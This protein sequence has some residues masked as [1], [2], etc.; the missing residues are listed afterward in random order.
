MLV[1]KINGIDN[2]DFRRFGATLVTLNNDSGGSGKDFDC[3]F[4]SRIIANVDQKKNI[5]NLLL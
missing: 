1:G 4:S 5:I 3:L 2:I